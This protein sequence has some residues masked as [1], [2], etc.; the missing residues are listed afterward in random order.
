VEPLKL[1][2]FRVVAKYGYRQS[3]RV[4]RS[5]GGHAR[6]GCSPSPRRPASMWVGR[7]CS[8]AD[9]AT[10]RTGERCCSGSSPGTPGPPPTSSP[11]LPDGWW[12]S[13]CRSTSRAV[14]SFGEQAMRV[15]LPL[16]FWMLPA[17]ALG[18]TPAPTRTPAEEID[19]ELAAQ[20]KIPEPELVIVTDGP[21]PA[22]FDLLEG[23]VE[24]DGRALPGPVQAGWGQEFFR[25]TV[26]PGN[27]VLTAVLAYRG[28]KTGAYPWSGSYAYRVPGKVEFQAQRGLRLVVHL[29]VEVREE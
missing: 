16:A 26:V 9:G 15:M 22:R 14:A 11:S 6:W 2:F 12:S 7:R 27:H 8:P 1:G 10:W 13:G 24:L 20:V 18:G 29:R 4:P 5:S 21:D 23:A 17:M 3:P 19:A 25:G 28:S